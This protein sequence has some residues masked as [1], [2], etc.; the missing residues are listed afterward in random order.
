VFSRA[1]YAIPMQMY[2]HV[3]MNNVC[4]SFDL[5]GKSRFVK[6]T[7][8]SL[9]A[10]GFQNRVGERRMLIR[11]S[12]YV[13]DKKNTCSSVAVKSSQAKPSRVIGSFSKLQPRRRR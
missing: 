8:R 12:Y 2:L 5:V 6:Y 10:W 3:E 9:Q 11:K 1:E 13:V 7:Y 4:E